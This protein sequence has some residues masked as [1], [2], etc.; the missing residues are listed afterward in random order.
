MRAWSND[1]L[2]RDPG[3]PM[4]TAHGIQSMLKLHGYF[5]EQMAERRRAPRDDMMSVLVSAEVDGEKLDQKE[6]L[7]F[8]NLLATAGNETVTKLLA[9]AFYWL[10]AFPDQRRILVDQP[11]LIPNAV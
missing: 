7:G 2:H 11:E 1:L 8:C 6:I 3:S 4:P 9:S 10:N 5:D